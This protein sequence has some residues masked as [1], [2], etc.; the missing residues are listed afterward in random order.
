LAGQSERG[1][2]AKC[3]GK[4]KD[5]DQGKRREAK[6]GKEKVEDEQGHCRTPV[7]GKESQEW[8]RV[9]CMR[10]DCRVTMVE[11]RH[12]NGTT[13]RKSEVEPR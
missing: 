9:E 12:A 2:W 8:S 7:G 6:E 3:T 4:E 5:K 10:P 1:G 11:A 13:Q